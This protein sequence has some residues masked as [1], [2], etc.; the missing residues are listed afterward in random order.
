MAS[1]AKRLLVVL[2]FVACGSDK[3]P[4][5]PDGGFPSDG[6]PRDG[7]GAAPA[8]ALVGDGG[9]TPDLMCSSALPACTADPAGA[10][11]PVCQARCG[12]Q[13]RCALFSGAPACVPP[14][15]AP[16]PLGGSC[17]ADLDDCTAG[18]ICL[19]EA[20]PACGSHCYRFCRSDADCAGGA[21]CNLEV[22]VK[23]QPAARACGAAPEACDPTGAGACT[24][25]DRPSP[26]FGCYVLSGST[27]DKAACDC[28]GTRPLGAACMFEHECAPG[29]ECV[30][31]NAGPGMCRKVCHLGRAADCPGGGTCAP[32]GTAAAP[33]TIFGYCAQ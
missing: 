14:A 13:Q 27:P 15:A 4:V 2:L 1:A 12:C 28:A 7:G 17:S 31:V 26:T 3:S 8:D 19:G 29:T 32:L 22:V 10:C 23:D 18:T 25:A 9:G 11:D 20:L 5:R 21:L 6:A 24:S 16:V 30:A 33:S